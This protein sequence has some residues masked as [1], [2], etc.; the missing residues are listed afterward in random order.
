MNTKISRYRKDCVNMLGLQAAGTLLEIPIRRFTNGGVLNLS[1]RWPSQEGR[2]DSTDQELP[3]LH[4][5][6]KVANHIIE[7]MPVETDA[8]GSDG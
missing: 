8:Y 4:I 6:R 7:Q 1:T 3:I 5:H 2:P